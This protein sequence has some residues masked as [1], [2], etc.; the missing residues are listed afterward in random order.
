MARA[1]PS[2]EFRNRGA[3]SCVGPP[4]ASP[5]TEGEESVN[6]VTQTEL[7]CVWCPVRRDKAQVFSG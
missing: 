3:E 5:E 7:K 6:P 4:Q 1:L 2:V